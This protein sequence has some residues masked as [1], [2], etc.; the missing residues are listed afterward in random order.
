MFGCGTLGDR[1]K[2]KGEVWYVYGSTGFSLL[3][4]HDDTGKR[5]TGVSEEW[6]SPHTGTDN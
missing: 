1:L 2:K 4:I 3:F 6:L 5:V